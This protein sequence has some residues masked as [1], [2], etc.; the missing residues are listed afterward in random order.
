M[1]K[2]FQGILCVVFLMQALPWILQGMQKRQFMHKTGEFQEQ[3]HIH[4]WQRV[5][6]S[7]VPEQLCNVFQP[8]SRSLSRMCERVLPS[9]RQLLQMLSEM[10]HLRSK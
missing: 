2:V 1:Q 8:E 5:G 7:D 4:H 6:V 3:N 9:E 10:S